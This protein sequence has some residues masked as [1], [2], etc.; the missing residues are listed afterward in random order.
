MDEAARTAALAR[1]TPLLGEWTLESPVSPDLRGRAAF[2]WTLGGQYMLGRTEVPDSGVP[3]SITVIS[4][5]DDG[6]SY[7]QH[8]F[9]SRGVVRVYEMTFGADGWTLLRERPDFSPLSFHQRYIG[10]LADDGESILGRW[11]K[12]YDGSDWE[13]DFE[14]NFRRPG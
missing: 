12:S 9:D 3:D 8:Y 1:L 11:E 10:E 5:N 7:T 6:E 13:L 14:L 2:E 4:V